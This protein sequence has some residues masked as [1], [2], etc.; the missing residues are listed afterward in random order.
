MEL[1]ASDPERYGTQMK[2]AAATG[3]DQKSWSNYLSGECKPSRLARAAIHAALGIE[4]FLWDKRYKRSRHRNDPKDNDHGA[5]VPYDG[6]PTAK[7]ET[8]TTIDVAPAPSLP[9]VAS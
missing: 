4:P 3:L 7:V 8:P 6:N 1:R 9:A 2:L 5:Q